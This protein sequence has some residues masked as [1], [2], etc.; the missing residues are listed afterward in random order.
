MQ[1]DNVQVVSSFGSSEELQKETDASCGLNFQEHGKDGGV[2]FIYTSASPSMDQISL[3]IS[4]F[5]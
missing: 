5:G 3:S 2:Q 1:H 4:G